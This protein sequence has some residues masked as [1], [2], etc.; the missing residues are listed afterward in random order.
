M[1][2]HPHACQNKPVADDRRCHDAM[3]L[4]VLRVVAEAYDEDDEESGCPDLV[5]C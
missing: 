4:C 1:A 5:H 2:F 3:M